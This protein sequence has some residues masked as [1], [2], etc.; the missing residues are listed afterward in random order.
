MKLKYFFVFLGIL[1]IIQILYL[2]LKFKRVIGFYPNYKLNRIIQNHRWMYN[3]DIAQYSAYVIRNRSHVW[4][5]AMVFIV[6]T[7]NTLNLS[8]VM[9]LIRIEDTGEIVEKRIHTALKAYFKYPRKVVVQLDESKFYKTDLGVA[10]FRTSNYKKDAFHTNVNFQLADVLEV[11]APRKKGLAQCIAHVRRFKEAHKVFL[12]AQKGFGVDAIILHDSTHDQSLTNFLRNNS[13]YSFITLR[14]YDQNPDA[15]CNRSISGLLD[16]GNTTHIDFYTQ[17]CLKYARDHIERLSWNHEELSLNDCYITMSYTYEFVAVYDLDEFVFPRTIDPQQRFSDFKLNK[18]RNDTECHAKSICEKKGFEFGLYDYIVK[19]LNKTNHANDYSD[20]NSICFRHV[21][22]IS[23]EMSKAIMADLK[24]L[25]RK[26]ETNASLTYPFVHDVDLTLSFKI[27]RDDRDYLDY[28]IAF[29]A[30][31]QCFYSILNNSK[32]IVNDFKRY[33]YHILPP[34]YRF[35][36]C[37][38]HSKN[39]GMLFAHWGY[40][41]RGTGVHPNVTIGEFLPHFRA[42]LSNYYYKH[43]NGEKLVTSI[44]DLNID[45]EYLNFIIKNYTDTCA[46]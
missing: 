34:N 11:H 37:I 12:H 20:L 16:E 33:F 25:I 42:D 41:T 30:E 3:H 31:L 38:H 9:C 1:C 5:E 35:G 6:N 28:L 32:T 43:K 46:I 21:V 18:T 22:M 7:E 8:D 39:V 29:D 45:S 44:R 15:M 10:V 36:K 26:M 13:D 4:I 19:I 40:H 27:E 23:P 14:Q 2:N 17:K 24:D